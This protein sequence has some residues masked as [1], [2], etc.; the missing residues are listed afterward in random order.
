PYRSRHAGIAHACGHD[1]HTAAVLGAGLLLLE[2]RAAEPQ[3]GTVR[4][5]FEPSEEVVPGGAVDVIA[6]GW[7]DGVREIFG[8]HCDPKTDVGSLGLRSGPLTSAALAEQ[9]AALAGQEYLYF[10]DAVSPIVQA[11]SIDMS[12]AFRQSRYERGEQTEGDYINCPMTREE[13]GAFIEA[14]LA[15]ETITL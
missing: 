15:A 9:I 5:V 4:L 13:Y 8:V 7:L 11:D 12:I 3:A 6:D 14:L 10:Y 2:A 1:V